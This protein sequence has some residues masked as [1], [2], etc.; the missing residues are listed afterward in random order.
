MIK[1]TRDDI[2]HI[3]DQDTLM[4]F[5]A[6]KLNLPIPEG[7]ALEDVTTKFSNFALGLKG[8]AANQVLDCQEL[9]ISPGEFSGIILIR[10]TIESGYAEALRAVAAGLD[11]LGRNPALS[12]FICTNEYF[13]PFASARF[14]DSTTKDWNTEVLNIFAW[15]QGNTHINIRA[16]HD[17][18][19]LFSP[20][21]SSAGSD[22]AAEAVFPNYSG[23]SDSSKNLLNKVQNTGVPLVRLIEH[24]KIH[25]GLI[26]GCA[27]AFI[28]DEYVRE[29]LINDD[30]KSVELIKPFLR[31]RKWIG[32]PG[33]VICIPSSK[34]IKWPW[35][36]TRD[37]S[38]AERIF[39]ETYPA[40]SDHMSYHKEKLKGRDTFRIR[41]AF[42]YWEFPAYN[43]YSVLERPKI[44]YPPTT[45]SMRVAYD[46]S[47][48]LTF[49]SAFFSTTDLSLLTILNS[50]LF[51]WYT[52]KKYWVPDHPKHLSL[53]KANMEK[54]P[55]VPRTEEQK[56]ELSNLARQILDASDSHRTLDIETEI[57]RLIYHLYELTPREIDS[58]EKGNSE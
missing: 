14:N 53:K 33:H 11:R 26:L 37:E 10:F 27:R 32:K 50:K 7:L 5:L 55:I 38:E 35:S 24:G 34:N 44:F 57:D 4:R 30:P 9:S 41:S 49:S 36:G 18:S 29:Q 17:L 56:T 43:L 46:S 58:I 25:T 28:I 16:E 15:A 22:N 52:H 12:R 47:Q 23:E 48:K 2:Q 31:P 42:F 39:R 21:A 1:I 8:M 6:G 3:S 51:A 20:Q 13:Q 40:I 45:S 19:V 54:L